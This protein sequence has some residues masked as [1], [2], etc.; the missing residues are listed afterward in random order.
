MEAFGLYVMFIMLAT[1]VMPSPNEW[2]DEP[3]GM[4][5]CRIFG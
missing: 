5:S 1:R 2:V 3:L 4:L